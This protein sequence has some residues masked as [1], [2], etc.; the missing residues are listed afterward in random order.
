MDLEECDVRDVSVG[1]NHVLALSVEGKLFVAGEG[2]NGQLGVDGESEEW[3]EVRLPL[4]EG[5]RIR[6]V[7]AGYK[8]SFVVVENCT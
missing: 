7:W 6:S 8:N 4:G 3:R 5:M 1:M 2:D